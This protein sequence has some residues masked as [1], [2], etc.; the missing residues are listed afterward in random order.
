[1]KKIPDIIVRNPKICGGEPTIRGT[2]VLAKTILASLA[3]GDRAEGLIRSFP[4]LT[5]DDIEAVIAYS[6]S[7]AM[8]SLSR[9]TTKPRRRKAA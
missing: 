8:K 4:T 7:I 1:M 3:S 6:A 2:R 5:H 9:P